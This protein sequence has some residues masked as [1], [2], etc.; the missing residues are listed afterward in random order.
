M[1]ELN[2]F[3]I[4]QAS[5]GDASAFRKL[6]DHYAPYVWRVAYKTANG[7]EDAAK[8]IVQDTFIRVHKALKKFSFS[9]AFSTWLYRIAFNV[10]QSFFAANHRRREKM[11]EYAEQVARTPRTSGAGAKETAHRLLALLSPRDR[12]LIIAREV[13]RRPFDELAT[14][15]GQSAGALRVHLHRLRESLR[16]E[17]DNE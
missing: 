3:T 17:F 14:I 2:D 9:S 6:Y 4:K 5:R 13:D 1:N 7:D 12:F 11:T 10:A 16:K 15:T 8:Q